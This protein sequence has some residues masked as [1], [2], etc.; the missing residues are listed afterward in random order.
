MRSERGR[1]Q[2]LKRGCQSTYVTAEDI[3]DAGMIA[4]WQ[5]PT[6]QYPNGCIELD[7]DHPVVRTQIEH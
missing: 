1:F 3:N 7:E 6:A 2:P 5:K 4:A